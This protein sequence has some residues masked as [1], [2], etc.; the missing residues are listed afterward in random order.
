MVLLSAH[1]RRFVRPAILAGVGLCSALASS[2][3]GTLEND[4]KA[5][6]LYNFTK[7]IAWPAPASAPDAFHICTIAD[8]EFTRTLDRTIAGESVDGKP[9]V[10]TEPRSA[11]DFRKCAILYIGPAQADRAA[12]LIAPV[13]DL[14][15]LTVGEGRPFIDQGG[16]IAFVL[17]NNRVRFDI[18]MRALQRAGLKASSKL[19][20]VARTVEGSTR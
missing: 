10:R 15:V 4:V 13:R 2:A 3:Q 8:Q 12:H 18:N 1:V 14:P 20:R 6:F 16:S 5:V 11:N 19:L 17:E 7:F 9:L